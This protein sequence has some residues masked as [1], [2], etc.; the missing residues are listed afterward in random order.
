MK[1]QQQSD[2]TQSPFFFHFLEKDRTFPP[3]LSKCSHGCTDSLFSPYLIFLSISF[4]SPQNSLP[5]TT[6]LIFP[7]LPL[8]SLCIIPV[9]FPSFPLL[10]YKPSSLLYLSSFPASALHT[11]VPPLDPAA[12][13]LCG[14]SSCV[15]VWCVCL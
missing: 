5:S 1:R 15:S 12:P 9:I 14:P 3:L 10:A 11:V 6:E 2:L 7:L 13:S 4:T 8:S